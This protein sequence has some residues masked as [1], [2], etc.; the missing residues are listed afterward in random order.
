MNMMIV[1]LVGTSLLA[2]AS[3]RASEDFPA[4]VARVILSSP[5]ANDHGTNSNYPLDSKHTV[6]VS[7]GGVVMT[8]G[9]DTIVQTANSAPPGF[10]DGTVDAQYAESVRRSFAAQAARARMAAGT[11]LQHPG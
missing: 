10:F 4:P 5:S 3:A 1:A 8:T 6:V 9:G 7:G 11:H 2:S